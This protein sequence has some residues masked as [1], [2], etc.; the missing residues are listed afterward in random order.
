MN[1]VI[2]YGNLGKDVEPLGKALKINVAT[3][4]SVK[5]GDEWEDKTEWHNVII[6]KHS[7]F[8]AENLKKGV[9]VLIE[10]KITYSKVNEKWYTNIVAYSVTIAQKID[11]KVKETQADFVDD[12]NLPF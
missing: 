7:D 6:T 2:L 12:G 3:T 11:V 1:K 9:K 4:S 8:L 5:N 10:G